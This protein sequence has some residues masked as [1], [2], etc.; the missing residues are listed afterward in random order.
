M[1]LILGIIIGLV[2]GA[3]SSILTIKRINKRI[4]SNEWVNWR[5]VDERMEGKKTVNNKTRATHNKIT[6]ETIQTDKPKK[7]RNPRKNTGKRKYYK[8][9]NNTNKQKKVTQS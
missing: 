2:V 7:K 8:K 9:N 3:G 5:P 1:E 4:K 6:D